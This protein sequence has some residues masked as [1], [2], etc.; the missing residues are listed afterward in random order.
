MI[1]GLEHLSH[2]ERYKEL[3]SFRL[4]KRKVQ[5][6]L[7]VTFQYIKRTYKKAGEGLFVRDCGHRTRGSSFKLKKARF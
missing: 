7:I 1:K 5:G 2:K 3:R 6:D 4:K